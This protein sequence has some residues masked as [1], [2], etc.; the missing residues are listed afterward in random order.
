MAVR[1]PGDALTAELLPAFHD[2]LS[3]AAII[4]LN[5]EFVSKRVDGED[6]SAL[7]DAHVSTE[8]LVR[9]IR[10]M[11]AI[12]TKA[13]S[14]AVANHAAAR[15]ESDRAEGVGIVSLCRSVL[16]DGRCEALP[17]T[18]GA[19]RKASSSGRR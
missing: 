18:S 14:R 17:P 19:P 10:T 2:L 8:R 16:G 3:Q 5:L 15:H 13:S 9:I 12:V 11:E 7:D 6:K 1:S 4:E